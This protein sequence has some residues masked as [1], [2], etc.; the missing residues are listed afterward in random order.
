MLCK[1]SWHFR[2]NLRVC[3][4]WDLYKVIRVY[5]VIEVRQSR[6]NSKMAQPI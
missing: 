5:K 6:L 4:E 2:V 3:E 1:V